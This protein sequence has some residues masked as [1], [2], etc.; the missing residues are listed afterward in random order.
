MV[1]ARGGM[2]S[3]PA[4]PVAGDEGRT[5][6]TTKTIGL[7]FAGLAMLAS[8]A[9]ALAAQ[10]YP[11]RFVKLI[12]PFG[13]G[14]SADVVGRVLA[15][16]VGEQ[17][18]QQLVIENKPGADADLGAEAVAKAQPDGYTLLLTTQVIAVNESL[19]AKRPYKITELQPVMLVASTQAALSVSMTLPV[20]SVA[21]LVALAKAKPGT[22]DF[23]STGIGTSGH[24][25]MELFRLATNI[26]I[27]HI[28]FRNIGQQM[29]DLIAGRI[30]MATP[31]VPGAVPHIRGGRIKPLAVTGAARSPTFPELPTM[32]EAGVAGY[33]A[34]TWF[35][36]FA[37]GGTPPEVVAKV[38]AAFGRALT[39]PE[40]QTRMSDLGVEPQGTTPE[41]LARHLATEIARWGKVVREAGV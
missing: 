15:K 32:Q 34:T 9:A 8:P 13:P 7:L 38:N 21:E 36:L 14:G 24:L 40:V 37:P 12:V 11:S 41:Q 26:D 16:A 35:G 29:T 10:T 23:G 6:V 18:G 20:N 33:E 30:A 25:T 39:V 5:R 17:W 28:P 22:L 19:R 31:T 27:V 4:R 3:R 1:F 2:R